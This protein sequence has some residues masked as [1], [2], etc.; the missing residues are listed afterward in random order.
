MNFRNGMIVAGAALI[1]VSTFGCNYGPS[2]VDYSQLGLVEISGIVTLDGE[3]LEGAGIFFH[4]RP[5][6]RYSYGVT[7]S[8]GRYQLM[9]DTRQSGV[10]PG[11][12]EVEITSAKNPAADPSADIGEGL[13]DEGSAGPG[14]EVVPAK[15]NTNT[16]L[17][18]NVTV[19]DDSVNF[20]LKSD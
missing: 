12:K 5:N 7:D 2:E 13:D 3:P 10:M 14:N 18:Y 17:K 11:E 8:E 15:Y 6:R 4:D 20:D 1:L 16:T 19:S 9:L